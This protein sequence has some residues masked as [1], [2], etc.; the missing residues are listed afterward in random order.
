MTVEQLLYNRPKT[1]VA[2][3]HVGDSAER[4]QH[5]DLADE[6]RHQFLED[7]SRQIR[8]SFDAIMRF[9]ELLDNEQLPAEQKEESH[10]IHEACRSLILLSRDVVR[11]VLEHARKNDIETLEYYFGPLLSEINSMMSTWPEIEAKAAAT[12][13][14]H[15]KRETMFYSFSQIED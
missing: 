7:M 9:S 5:A 2:P 14:T 11:Y 6:A 4:N 13:K 8:S 15:Q 12:E 10:L 3:K 1:I